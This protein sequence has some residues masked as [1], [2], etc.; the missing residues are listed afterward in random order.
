[1]I[2][3][4]NEVSLL[5]WNRKSSLLS[6][7]CVKSVRLPCCFPGVLIDFWLFNGWHPDSHQRLDRRLSLLRR[8]AGGRAISTL[9]VGHQRSGRTT[10]KPRN[11]IGSLGQKRGLLYSQASNVTGANPCCQG[12]F[13]DLHHPPVGV[14][15][16]SQWQSR[17]LFVP[18]GGQLICTCVHF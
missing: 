16:T 2:H 12:L 5:A 8:Y 10:V 13:L 9:Q 15:I 7:G 11:N 18:H 1:M 6:H 4:Y 14:C 3:V 17:Q